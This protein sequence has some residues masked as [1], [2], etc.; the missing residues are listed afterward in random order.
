MAIEPAQESEPLDQFLPDL[1]NIRMVFV[2]ILVAQMLVFILMLAD[3]IDLILRL[4]KFALTTLFVQWLALLSS[5]W[6]CLARRYL[7]LGLYQTATI[8][9]VGVLII[10]WLLSELAWAVALPAGMW[11]Y[12]DV[13]RHDH[14]VLRNI[15]IGAIVTALS[16]RYFYVQY[17]WKRRIESESQARLQALQSRIRPHFFFNCMNT[18]ASLTRSRP[19]QAEQAVEDLADVFRASLSDARQQISLDEELT[20]CRCYLRIESLRLGDRL[21][22]EWQLDEAAMPCLLPA[23]TLQPLIENAIYHGIE[24]LASGGL[25]SIE[26]VIDSGRLNITIT[27]PVSTENN[28]H[29]HE[30]NRLALA[31]IRERLSVLHGTQASVQFQ[32]DEPAGVYRVILS[33]PL[34]SKLP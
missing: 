32:L 28:R 13:L 18:I 1:C 12:M 22:V 29:H 15:F 8:G 25:V 26:T 2:V 14:F 3:G 19:E 23:L 34:E 6:L 9:F 5:G 17:H 21:Q 20:L 27:N 16:L 10:I 31:N 11:G 24:P 30:G 4:E 7:K 33:L